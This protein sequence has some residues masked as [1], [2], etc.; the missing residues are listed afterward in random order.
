MS[1]AIRDGAAQIAVLE[2]RVLE[3]GGMIN[4]LQ[5][6]HESLQREIVDRHPSFPLPDTPANAT[7]LL[8]DQAVLEPTSPLP[9]ALPPLIDLSMADI[10]PTSPNFE[11]ASAID[12]LTFEPSQVQLP[13]DP[14]PT[15]EDAQTTREI[16]PPDDPLNLV[17]DYNSVDSMDVEVEVGVKPE[18]VEVK[19]DSEG[20]SADVDMA[21]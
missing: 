7:S 11:D 12:G 14:L 20:H 13:P 2:A 19:V 9:L 17:P 8:L 21:T 5:R 6:L 16:I 3:Q 1:I 4:T 18:D 10:E 15:P